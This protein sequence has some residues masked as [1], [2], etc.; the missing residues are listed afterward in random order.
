MTR[1]TWKRFNWG[2]S[3]AV[4][5]ARFFILHNGLRKPFRFPYSD[6]VPVEFTLPSFA[7][8]NLYLRVLG[9]RDDGYHA[10][11]YFGHIC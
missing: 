5:A 9:R 10:E 2:T 11:T 7:K 1:V 4:R 8:V 6:A 3:R